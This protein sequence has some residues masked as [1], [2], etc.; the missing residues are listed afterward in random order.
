AG[1]GYSFPSFSRP[2]I[3]SRGFAPYER[4]DYLITSSAANAHFF[5]NKKFY[6]ETVRIYENLR[7]K[8]EFVKSFFFREIEYKNPELNLYRTKAPPRRKQRMALP[9]AVPAQNPTREFEMADGSPYGKSVM[10][11]F[12]ENGRKAERIILSRKKI[13]RLA[14]FVTP[15][16]G[17]G[18]LTIR[19]FT[20]R[21]TLPVRNGTPASLVFEP[22]I[23]FP[24]YPY[25]YKVSLQGI[26]FWEGAVKICHDDF[27][28]GLEF[29][30]LGDYETARAY[31]MEA[32]KDQPK[33]RFDLE[34]YLYLAL[35]AQRTGRGQEAEGFLDRAATDPAMRR[36]RS[37]FRPS[38]E[39]KE[40]EKDFEKF[41]GLN[42]PL[43]LEML[44]HV[45][46]KEE[47]IQ[48]AGP[49][50]E[51]GLRFA[52]P[53]MRLLAAPQRLEFRLENPAGIAGTVGEVEVISREAS[54]ENRLAFPLILE[55]RPD[56]PFSRA[57]LGFPGAGLTAETQLVVKIMHGERV[58]PDK[59]TVFPDLREFM[60]QK[61]ALFQDLRK[62]LLETD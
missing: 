60:R 17:D 39:Q 46:K 49:N 57:S 43:Y 36:Y 26:G 1:A 61:R 7:K 20:S 28:F 41:S 27:A 33:S 30:R 13:R 18:K 52:S 16:G 2:F 38:E 23:S 55:A 25:I 53:K 15:A 31:F 19:N 62:G 40:W 54:A 5:R 3:F 42:I 56:V 14:V 21:K 22:R 37:L 44:T 4:F 51:A 32:L 6:P 50:G 34:I 9:A 29:L 45:V 12:L 48:M 35:C 47:F 59:L 10:S 11:F 8:N 24:F 58:I